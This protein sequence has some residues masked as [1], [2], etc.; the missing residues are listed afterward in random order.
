MWRHNLNHM[1]TKTF[2]LLAFIFLFVS[3]SFNPDDP[4]QKRIAIQ[5]ALV[6]SLNTNHFVIPKYDN[7]LSEKVWGLFIERLDYNKLFFT[8]E[9]IKEFKKYKYQIDNQIMA[10]TFDFYELVVNTF[11]K[12]VSEAKEYEELALM[13]PFDFESKE[14]VETDPEKLDFADSKKELKS[15]WYERMKF[16]T[17]VRLATKMD[18]QEKK[19]E[20][21]DSSFKEVPFEEMEQKVRDNL[22]KNNLA[23]FK[24]LEK[25]KEADYFSMYMNSLLNAIDPHTGYFPPKDKEDFDI[26]MSGRLEGI[27]AT[28]TEKDGYIKVQAIVPGSASWKQGDLKAGDLILKVAQEGEEPVD[29]VDMRLDEAVKLIRGKKGTKVILTVKKMD[30]SIIDIA[31]VRDVVIIE[32]TYAKSSVILDTISGKSIGYIYLP[33][34]YADFSNPNGRR[35]ATDIKKEINKLKEEKVDG[36]VLDLRSNGG[37]SLSDVVEI[38]GYFIEEGPI[39]QVKGRWGAPYVLRDTDPE[40]LYDGPL[41][42]MI[43]SLS[44]SASEILA[45]AMQDYNRAIIVGGKA[46]FGKGTVQRFIDL[47]K[48]IMV[49]PKLRPL[50]AIK[51]TMQKF[52]RINGQATQLKGV[53]PDIIFPD[54]F[55]YVDY[56]ERELDYPLEWSTIDPVNYRLWDKFTNKDESIK[57]SLDRI[58]KDTVFSLLDENAKRLKAQSDVSMYDLNLA[59]YRLQ[60]KAL[61]E[62]N[63]KYNKIQRKNLNLQIRTP[64]ADVAYIEADSS[65]IARNNTWHKNLQKDHYLWETIHIVS[66]IH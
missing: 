40:V 49:D 24:R 37:G 61:K 21:P 63:K 53:T 38:G 47:D 18:V 13:K 6:Q 12:R 2:L 27:G 41:A 52:Y 62:K 17:L 22:K 39:V 56:G 43:N 5:D 26:R 35:C 25:M 19:S 36:I 45:A 46:S 9:D 1:K 65:R 14:K 32:E 29:I 34:F 64:E 42:I 31:I 48:I 3:F 10:H 11:E 44:A 66:E 4:N 51:I 7:D 59:A 20:K 55:K 15:R 54:V 57:N 60:Q 30:G 33:Q 23:W 16:Q 58:A 50:G 8:R 28:L